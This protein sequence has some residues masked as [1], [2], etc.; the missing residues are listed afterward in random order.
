MKILSQNG[1]PAGHLR[2]IK[3]GGVKVYMISEKGEEI[4]I[5]YRSEGE[6][7]GIVSMISGDRSRANIV[8]VE[9]TICYLV[10]RQRIMSILEKNPQVNE[11]FVKSFFL[12]LIDRT[13]EETRKRF[14]LIGEGERVLFT[15]PVKDI[16][17]RQPVTAVESM[18][19]KDAASRMAQEGISSLVVMNDSGIPAG[20]V[21]DRDLREKVVARG[22]DLNEPV[23][24][25][26]SSPLIRVDADEFC[27]EALLRMIR[28]NI[29]HLLVVEGGSLIG[30]VTNHDFMVLQGSSPTVFVK[31]IEDAQSI[32]ELSVAKPKLVKVVSE[33]LRE[34]ARASNVTGLITEITEKFILRVVD[35]VERKL[36]ASPI[37]YSLFFYCDG[38]RRE[39]TL[40]L[41]IKLGIVYDET[42][43][44]GVVSRAENYFDEFARVLRETMSAC[45]FPCADECITR[46]SIMSM[47][48]W[49]RAFKM[50]ASGPFV[51][52]M[53]EG[54]F[55]MHPIRGDESLVNLLKEFLWN[56]ASESEDLM[57]YLAT[58]TVQ[59]RP[60]LGFF[61]RFV[62]EKS[63][64]H[65][66][67]LNLYEKGIKPLVDAV[68]LFS[69]EKKIKEPSTLKRVN[70]LRDRYNFQHAGDIEQ[71]LEYIF[72]LLIHDQIG[73]AENGTSLDSFLNP[74]M[75]SNLEK[76]TL[77][78]T[79][80]L[81]AG[82]YDIIEKGYRTERVEG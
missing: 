50:W 30:V 65:I 59:N 77:K 31:E 24:L 80:L 1:P 81:I 75:L 19:I 66:N 51:Y 23:R 5:D 44:P 14:T 48:Q 27:F 45:G 53:D 22:R 39:F 2:L 37:P 7:F 57:D 35:I 36:G 38:G 63:G 82:L 73:H 60:P 10:P 74:E 56:L 40:N 11:Y 46:G 43:N 25:I 58:R 70:I 26:M 29:H 3:K 42:Q 76:K 18:T 47:G 62:V 17:R 69:I 13:Y 72:A 32:E 28:Y 9:D 68:R 12:N 15:T 52:E 67:E 21:T 16:V 33:L 54:L 6:Q 79:F 64:E 61:K 34:G 20:I 49:K 78:E 55:D 8:A 4:T 41:H 71:A